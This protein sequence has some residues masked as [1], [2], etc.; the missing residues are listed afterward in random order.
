MKKI[1]R[2]DLN[3]NYI[4]EFISI[5]EAER[6]TKIKASNIRKCCRGKRD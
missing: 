4:D 6:Q 2:M 3:N 5:Q 1:K